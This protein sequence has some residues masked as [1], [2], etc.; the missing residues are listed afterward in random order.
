MPNLRV[1]VADGASEDGSVAIISEW[2]KREGHSDWISILPLEIN[3]GFGWAHNQVMLTAL[4]S[5][6]P[7]AF[8]HLLNPDTIIEPGAVATLRRAFEQDARIGCVG[9][10]LVNLDGSRGGGA[11]RFPTI[12]REF[13]NGARIG[14]IEKLFGIGPGVVFSD[15][16][17]QVDWV[18]GA[19]M[20]IRSDALKASG[21]FDDG[22]F[23]YWEEVELMHRLS[24][25]NWKIWYEPASRVRH[26][27]GASTGVETGNLK[28]P[29]RRPRYFYVSRR[30]QFALTRGRLA[31]TL[32]GLAWI[33][34]RLIHKCVCL[35]L[36]S[37]KRREV[38][39]E[40]VDLWSAGISA[41][42][43][44][45]KSASVSWR[46]R[47]GVRPAWFDLYG[48]ELAGSTSRA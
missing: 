39:Y 16:A 25:M 2:I 33:A 27:G 46:S 23:L 1:V 37:R 29:K 8:I 20:M 11:F 34:G 35:A 22:F 24:R 3:G 18:T 40:V 5:D 6:T 26:E 13:A 38:P 4:Q 21:L 41:T 15:Q 30:R 47:P 32:A 12:R 44:D 48:A 43:S 7:P 10:Q 9:S 42:R 28:P 17:Q 31:T 36:P 45:M 19:S 14:K